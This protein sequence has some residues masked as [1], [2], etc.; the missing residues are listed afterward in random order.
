MEP[1]KIRI[2]TTEID[3]ALKKLKK[4]KKI[5]KKVM[6]KK[7]HHEGVRGWKKELKRASQKARLLVLSL[8]KNTS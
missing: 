6:P 1:I 7:R 8:P 2:D 3:T 4:L 5:K